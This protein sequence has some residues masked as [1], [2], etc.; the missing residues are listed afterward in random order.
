MADW[1]SQT[2]L[3]RPY[4]NWLYSFAD[5][6]RLLKEAGFTSIDSYLCFPDYRF[7]E[8]I[9]STTNSLND[10]YSMLPDKPSLK[11]KARCL[12][13]NFLFRKLRLRGLAPS[14]IAIART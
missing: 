8:K 13:E 1:M 9:L 3:R 7:P 12:L 14:M 4:V 10:F 11:R 2:K 5:L 6:E